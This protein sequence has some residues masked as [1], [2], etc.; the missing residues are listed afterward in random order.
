MKKKRNLS[1]I[2][3]TEKYDQQLRELLIADLKALHHARINLVRHLVFN[4]HQDKT[5]IA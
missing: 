1:V 3:L 4:N 2:K 5:M